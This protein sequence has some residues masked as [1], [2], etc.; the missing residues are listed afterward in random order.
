MKTGVL[1]VAIVVAVAMVVMLVGGYPA[2]ETAQAKGTLQ[3]MVTDAP[4]E[5][6]VTSIM[7]TVESVEVHKAAAQ[8]EQQ[9]DPQAELLKAAAKQAE[10]EGE[11]RSSKVADNLAS[12][13]KKAAETQKIL[14]ELPLNNAKTASEIEKNRSDIQQNLFSNVEGLPLN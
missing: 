4:P 7:V 9:Q 2:P 5:E 10:S 13:E 8:Q 1:I 11:E 3:I 6:E 14:S 12:A